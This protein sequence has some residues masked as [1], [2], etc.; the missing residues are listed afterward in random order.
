MEGKAYLTKLS[1]HSSARCLCNKFY[2]H[3]YYVVSTVAQW[4]S[5]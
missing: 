2:A 4:W 1:G 5:A 3:V